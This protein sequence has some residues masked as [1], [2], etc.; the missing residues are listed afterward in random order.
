M[1]SDLPD[2]DREMKIRAQLDQNLQR[3]YGETLHD[4][5]PDRFTRLLEQLRQQSMIPAC[6]ISH[7]AL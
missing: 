5:V 2:S 1:Y 6:G 4:V 7:K 3:I